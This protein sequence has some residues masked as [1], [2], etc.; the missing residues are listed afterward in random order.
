MADVLLAYRLEVG[1]D[2]RAGLGGSQLRPKA[3]ALPGGTL[4]HTEPIL[5]AGS[6]L[7]SGP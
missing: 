3:A 4:M 7:L 2:L 6:I 1:P 5:G